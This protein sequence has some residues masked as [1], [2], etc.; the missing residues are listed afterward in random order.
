MLTIRAVLVRKPMAAETDSTL[1]RWSVLCQH[2]G[3][4]CLLSEAAWKTPAV[5][6]VPSRTGTA[7][8]ERRPMSALRPLGIEDAVAEGENAK[9]LGPRM[10]AGCAKASRARSSCVRPPPRA[11]TSEANWSA[12]AVGSVRA[13]AARAAWS[14]PD[15]TAGNGIELPMRT[16]GTRQSAGI[17]PFASDRPSWR[18]SWAEMRHLDSTDGAGA[19]TLKSDS[20]PRFVGRSLKQ[21]RPRSSAVAGSLAQGRPGSTDHSTNCGWG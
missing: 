13:N 10:G 12:C 15:Q 8:E 18:D 14:I 6:N 7:I 17:S 4:S 2:A 3:E 20:L 11:L 21:N 16:E 19:Q 9:A 5:S 1:R